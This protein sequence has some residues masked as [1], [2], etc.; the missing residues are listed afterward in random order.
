MNAVQAVL[1]RAALPVSVETIVTATGLCA[2]EVYVELVRL[3]SE[4]KA[5]AH[6]HYFGRRKGGWAALTGPAPLNFNDRETHG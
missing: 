5:R 4:G 3:E 6:A 1:L 2:E